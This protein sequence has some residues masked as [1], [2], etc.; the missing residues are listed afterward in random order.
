MSPEETLLFIHLLYIPLG[1][2]SLDLIQFIF[3]G[4][5]YDEDDNEVEVE[6]YTLKIINKILRTIWNII[7]D[8]FE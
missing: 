5:G 3:Y 8:P 1:I 6:Y 4:D 7:P 2:L